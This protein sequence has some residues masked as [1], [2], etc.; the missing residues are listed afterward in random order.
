VTGGE[1][2]AAP[3]DTRAFRKTVGL[4]ATGVTV[5]A[6]YGGDPADD[7]VAAMTANA[8]SSVSLEPL[9]ILVCVDHRA[10]IASHLPVGQ[11]F[12]LN[13]LRDDQE[14]L[15]RYF[16][17]GWRNLP[18]P[19]FRFERWENVPR[20]VGS[21]AAIR[22]VVSNA[23]E[24]GDHTIV[25]GRVVGLF[26]G[27]GAWNPLLFYAGRYRRLAPLA[28]PS[29]PPEQWGPDGVSVYYEEWGSPHDDRG[30]RPDRR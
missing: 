18:R 29:A 21:L 16:G 4:F 12:S 19:E 9:L 3:P 14:V 13:I 1:P 11:P 7:G 5:V 25:L 15:S 23:Y 30:G 26:D 8:V 27:P 10:R 24:A 17:G 6:T 28:V 2:S 22:C 20:L